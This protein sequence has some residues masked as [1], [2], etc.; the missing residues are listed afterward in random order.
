VER[1]YGA[2]GSLVPAEDGG[3]VF[4][5]AYSIDRLL[6]S[7]ALRFGEHAR[8]L[9][10]AELVD[11]ARRRVDHLIEAHRGEPEAVRSVPPRAVVE[12]EANGRSRGTEAAIRPE[13][14]ARLVTLATVLISAARSSTSAPS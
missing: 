1:Q 7:W 10:P 12:V 4:T 5:T 11:E 8:V 3:H 6:I 2:Y 14:F 9:G 13:R